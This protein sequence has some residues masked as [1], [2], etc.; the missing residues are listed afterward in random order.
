MDLTE[1]PPIAKGLFHFYLLVMITIDKAELTAVIKEALQAVIK[2]MGKDVPLIEKPLSVKE[3]AD[4]LGIH[5]NT[6]YKRIKSGDLPTSL[7]HRMNGSVYFFASE[8]HDHIKR[9]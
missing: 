2:E 6:I 8:L 4:Y 1:S 7:I 5:Q 9:S 3:T